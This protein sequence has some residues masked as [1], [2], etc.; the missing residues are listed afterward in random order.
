MCWWE[1]HNS[2]CWREGPALE[3]EPTLDRAGLGGPGGGG[4]PACGRGQGDRG[5][6]CHGDQS[7]EREQLESPPF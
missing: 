3:A 4:R 6:H 7:R 1:G 2:V 5:D